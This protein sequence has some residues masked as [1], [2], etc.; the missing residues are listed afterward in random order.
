MLRASN[1]QRRH[2]QPG[3]SRAGFTLIEIMA[4][5]TLMVIGAFSLYSLLFLAIQCD[6]ESAHYAVAR[7]IAQNQIDLIRCSNALPTASVP[8]ISSLIPGGTC[9]ISV[10]AQQTG[11]QPVMDLVTVTI[12]WPEPGR[13]TDT[14]SVW[15]YMC[16][17]GVTTS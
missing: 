13:G 17:G 15:T 3:R 1:S 6:S 14:V 11:S 7:T 2:I 8:S 5:L 16:V 12:K 9:S 4:A 10:S